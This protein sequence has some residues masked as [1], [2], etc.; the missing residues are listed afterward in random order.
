MPSHLHRTALHYACAY[1]H[2]EVVHLLLDYECTISV[3]DNEQC[4]PLIKASQREFH[5]C[6]DTL[7]T[8]GADPNDADMYGNTALHYA[9]LNDDLELADLLLAYDANIEA[10]TKEGFTPYL[11]ALQ[12]NKDFIAEFLEHMGADIHAEELLDRKHRKMHRRRMCK[13]TVRHREAAR[14]TSPSFYRRAT[15]RGARDSETERDEQDND[16]NAQVER[17]RKKC[18]LKELTGSEKLHRR[19]AATVSA[20]ADPAAPGSGS[21]APASSAAAADGTDPPVPATPAPPASPAPTSTPATTIPDVD[22]FDSPAPSACDTLDGSDAPDAP[23]IPDGTDTLHG[24]DSP[25]GPD[26]LDVPNPLHDP[27]TPTDLSAPADHAPLSSPIYLHLLFLLVLLVFFHLPLPFLMPLLFLLLLVMLC[28]Y[29]PHA[30]LASSAPDTAD[31][32]DTYD[33]PDTPDGADTPDDPNTT[34]GPNITDG[35][36]S[37]NGPDNSDRP[38]NADGPDTPDGPYIP[39]G[40]DT[41]DG[42]VFPDGSK[43]PDVPDTANGPYTSDAPDSTNVSEYP[44]GLVTHHGPVTSNASDNPDLPVTPDGLDACDCP[45]TINDSDNT[46]G[47]VTPAGPDTP[48]DLHTPGGQDSPDSSDDPD[49]PNT[50]DV[51]VTHDGP[52]N[53]DDP[54]TLDGPDNTVVL[55]NPVGPDTPDVSDTSDGLDKPDGPD[56]PDG[57]DTR[58]GPDTPHSMDTC[59]DP[60]TSA[61]PDTSETS[62]TSVGFEISNG[63]STSENP[64]VSDGPDAQDGPDSPAPPAALLDPAITVDADVPAPR[65]VPA[66]GPASPK[67]A[68]YDDEEHALKAVKDVPTKEKNDKN[69]SACPLEKGNKHEI[70]KSPLKELVRIPTPKTSSAEMDTPKGVSGHL[71]SDST[72]RM[73]RNNQ[74]FSY[75]CLMNGAPCPLAEEKKSENS[76]FTTSESVSASTSAGSPFE[77]GTVPEP[78]VDGSHVSGDLHRTGRRNERAYPLEKGNKSALTKSQWRELVRIPTRETSASEMDSPYGPDTSGVPDTLDGPDTHDGL[79]TCDGPE[80]TTPSDHPDGPDTP[81]CTDIS[82]GPHNP[83]GPDIPD[84]ADTPDGLDIPVGSDNP[85]D[86]DTPDGPDTPYSLGTSDD[87]DPSDVPDASEGPSTPVGPITSDGCSTS[88]NP[89]VSHGP[90]T[91]DGPES[92]APLAALLDPAIS[93]EADVP[94]PLSVPADGPASPN[95][96]D[97]D[98]EE[99]ALQVVKVVPTKEKNDKNESA[100]PL[101]K[102]NKREITKRPFN[103]LVRTSTPKTSTAKMDTLVEVNGRRVSGEVQ[104]TGSRLNDGE[105]TVRLERNDQAF[106]YKCLRNERAYPLE[107]EN[108]SAITKSQLRE[109]VRIPTRETSTSEMDSPYG[110]DSSGGPDPLEGLDTHDGLDTCDGPD[111]TTVSDNADSP[112]SPDGTDTS[113]GPHNPDGPDIPDGPDTPDGADIPVG[114]DNPHDPDTP[115]GPDT[116]YSLGTSDDPDPS[117]VPDTSEGPSTPVGPITSDGCSTSESPRVSH[118]PNA[119]DGPES[120][121]PLAALLDRAISEEA[122]VPAPLSVPADGPP[123]PNAADYDDEEHALQVAKVV[124]AK[125]KNDKNESACPLEKVN[126]REITKSPLNEL[127]RT[128]TPKTSTAEMDTLMEVN[129]HRVSESTVRLERNDQAFSYKC[130]RNERAYPLEKGNK[131]AIT[132]RQ[133][134]ELV[135]IPTRETSTSEM[136]SPYT[137]DSSGGTD[138]LDGL[139]THDGLDTCDGPDTTTVSDNLDG[140]DSPDGTDTSDG[141]HNADGPDIPDGPDTTDGADI[142]VGS[143]NPHDPDTPDGPDTPYSLGTSDDPDPSDVPDTSEGPS[144]PV[145]PI[146][147]D[148]CSTSESPRVSHGPNA[149]DGPESPAPLAALLDPAISAEADVPAPLSVPADGPASPNAAD[150]DDEEHALQVAKVVH[151][152]EKNDKNESAC[153]LE[154]VNKR[155]ITK[156]PLK[157]L[158]RPSTPKTST[159]EMD[160]LM[161]VNGHPLSESTIRL[162]RNDHAFPYKYLRKKRAYPLG[163]GNKSAI[164]KSQLRELVSIPTPET[165]TAGMDSMMEINSLSASDSTVGMENKYKVV[166]YKRLKEVNNSENDITVIGNEEMEK[167]KGFLHLNWKLGTAHKKHI[168]RSEPPCPLAEEKKSENSK[169]TTRESVSASTSERS[170]VETDTAQQ[171]QVDGSHVPGDLHHTGRRKER[172]YPLGKGNKSAITKSQLRELVSIPTPETSTAGMDSM[173]E[174]NSLSASDSTV[175]MENK[176]KVVP[177][178]RLKEVNNSENDITVIGNEEMEKH[179]GFLHLNWKLGTAH[180]KHIKRSEP[181]CP[182]AEEKKSENSKFTTRESVSA[183]TS[184][185]SPVETD[186]AQQAQVDGSHV[187]GDLHHTGRRA[188]ENTSTELH[189]VGERVDRRSRRFHSFSINNFRRLIFFRSYEVL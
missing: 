183:S 182:L 42:P 108:K 127:V 107:K 167:H 43:Y 23:H 111:T 68:D 75:K 78:Q 33:G 103:E 121:A 49:G 1:G 13:H 150:Y 66:D 97:Y 173:M 14:S 109:L 114:S 59:D 58:D 185:R 115:D 98:D 105:S 160:K 80:T 29:R 92:P 72:I 178:K 187:P 54:D 168:K 129:V 124:P 176:Y 113:D 139:D 81:D 74:A 171:A 110:P 100:C 154:K 26:S 71:V 73:E 120:P 22:P 84:G 28:P 41:S 184:E 27:D 83:D 180:K 181:P 10:K 132:K 64:R 95:A 88:E 131:S 44:D 77:M 162:E 144:T 5:L 135:R 46:H 79:D 116:P 17:V 91:Q 69:E 179:K 165:S 89:R 8:H 153:P 55:D 170:P 152:K 157:K 189:K 122:E 67:A 2:R 175:G 151:T 56:N 159:A 123:S 118:G 133:L 119:Q 34:D 101:E 3:F 147:S 30:P 6:V 35:N 62:T 20:A 163:K 50:C 16:F 164:T 4:T 87:P 57:P 125:E 161:E 18:L 146:T 156:S 61:V 37:P 9:A 53:H 155:E 130:L 172:A 142:P 31:G 102:V 85:H 177:Y 48:D 148:G 188:A 38:A 39:D 136:D 12:E 93:E 96:A 76:K 21:A 134:R 47:L 186:T 36:D 32:P 65:S 25:D 112:D 140:P 24:P 52:D 40:L 166:P 45:D 82:D 15:N 149:Q 143:D 99:H 145:G 94:A 11:L 70:T 126:K 158:V 137:P 138:P 174:I 104:H 169:F 90:N 128:S 106:S 7:L 117:D 63:S 19:A 51:P 60:D 141:P 86:P